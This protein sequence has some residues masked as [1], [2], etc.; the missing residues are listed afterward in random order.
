MASVDQT[1]QETSSKNALRLF[2]E[3]EIEN[4]LGSVLLEPF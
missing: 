4:G 2:I 3:L 1:W